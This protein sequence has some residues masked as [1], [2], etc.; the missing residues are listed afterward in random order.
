MFSQDA[1]W[2]SWMMCLAA[3]GQNITEKV[4]KF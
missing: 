1:F 2:Q 3:P 4:S